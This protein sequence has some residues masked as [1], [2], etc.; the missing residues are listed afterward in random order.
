MGV[1]D[2]DFFFDLRLN[3][4]VKRTI[5]YAKCFRYSDTAIEAS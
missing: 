1:D 2:W 3:L 4:L 5:V